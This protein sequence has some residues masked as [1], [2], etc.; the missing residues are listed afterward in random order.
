MTTWTRRFSPSWE[1]LSAP[2]PGGG[3]HTRLTLALLDRLGIRPPARILDAGC[4]WGS[5]L[6]GLE[7]AGYRVVGADI[8]RRALERLDR[9]DRSLAVADLTQ[10][11]P[12]GLKLYLTRP[13]V[14]HLRIAE[15]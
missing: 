1:R 9:T 11:L 14:K 8:S 7:R 10:P 13:L 12:V 3:P 15:S 5:T 4:G 6:I 2:T